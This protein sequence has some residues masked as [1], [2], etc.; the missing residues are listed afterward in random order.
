MPQAIQLF[1]QGILVAFLRRTK[2]H[3]KESK[4]YL[5]VK[6][7]TAFVELDMVEIENTV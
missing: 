3:K 2:G 7:L 4:D 6:F 1:W 5:L